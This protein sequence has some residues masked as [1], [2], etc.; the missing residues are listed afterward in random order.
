MNHQKELR[1][2]IQARYGGQ[3]WSGCLVMG[4]EAKMTD[5]EREAFGR[6]SSRKTAKTAAERDLIA[7]FEQL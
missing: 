5:G 2:K 3:C 6:G 7:P 1:L 4:H